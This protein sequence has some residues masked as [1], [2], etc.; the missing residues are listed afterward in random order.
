MVARVIADKLQAGLGRTV[1]VENRPGAG[2]QIAASVLMK[3]NA[4]GHTL[5]I[6]DTG[7]LAVNTTLYPKL[8]FDP[9]K[10][11][12][13]VTTL[14]STPLVLVVSTGSKA[15]KAG[16]IVAQAKQNP[17]GLSYA[18]QGIGTIG[19]PAGRA[20]ARAQRRPIPSRGLQGL[21]PGAAGRDRRA[22][23]HAVRPGLHRLADDHRRQG[24][25]PGVAAARRSPALPQVPTL[26]E[27]GVPGV[28]GSVWWGMVVKAG[29]P[30]AAVDRL[31]A[32][33]RKALASPD[34]VKRFAELGHGIDADELPALRRIPEGRGRRAGRRSSRPA[35]RRSIEGHAMTRKLKAAIVGSGNIGTDLMIKILRHGA[36]VEMGA[37]VGIDPASDGL[38]R[39]A[40]MGVA[41]THEGVEG[42]TRLPVFDDIDIV[43]D[44]TSAGAH[45]K[46][47][48]FLRSLKPG[49]R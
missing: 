45:V 26:A 18:S 7:A 49:I 23:G 16:D 2:A 13:P 33:I 40:R 24:Q 15:A 11:F 14:V 47:D 10:D 28:E 20:T 19:P 1:I 5:M 6:G 4:D 8:S 25:G 43:F 39:A 44:A 3:A 35:A 48:A 21:D 9:L 12:A 46:N 36:H 22:S 38:A 31:N 42:L 30:P 41:T 32:E 17:Q 27:A 37:M 34:V 29:T